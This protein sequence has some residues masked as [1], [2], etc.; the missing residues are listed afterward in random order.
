MKRFLL[1]SLLLVCGL[2]AHGQACSPVNGMTCTPN[3]NLYL[4]PLNYQN[5]NIALNANFNLLDTSSANWVKLN[6]LNTFTQIQTMPGLVITGAPSGT[7]AKADGTGY[8]TP[9]GNT[10]CTIGQLAYYASGG[11]V[12]AC[13]NLGTGLTITSGTLNAAG[14]SGGI[15]QLTGDVN[16]TG[17]NIATA[18]LTAS[19]VTA[20]SYTGATITVDAKGRV[21]AAATGFTSGSNTNGYWEKS[22]TGHIHQW[23]LTTVSS[24]T[25]TITFP[26][27][28]TILASII[29]SGSPLGT[30]SQPSADNPPLFWNVGLNGMSIN[31]NSS[32]GASWTADGY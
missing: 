11:A 14:G 7:Y 22:P 13:L 27:P 31:T 9:A 21:T 2:V 18:T 4:P 29:P 24:S 23:G 32:T 10:P 19:G 3:L 12:Q 15:T 5:W 26:T 30:T 17:P 20:G 6:A 25:T 8:G 16:A 28:F 1:I